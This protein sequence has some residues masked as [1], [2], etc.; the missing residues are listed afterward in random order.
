MIKTFLILRLCLKQVF[1]LG[2]RNRTDMVAV[3]SSEYWNIGLLEKTV[4]VDLG[5]TFSE[6]LRVETNYWRLLVMQWRC[7]SLAPAGS[8]LNVT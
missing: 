3:T 5:K 4:L 2:V 8:Q 1:I 7:T 6:D